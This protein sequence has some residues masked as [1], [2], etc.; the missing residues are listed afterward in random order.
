MTGGRDAR[1]S[2]SNQ[3]LY[4]TISPLI[5]ED[6]FASNNNISREV[7]PLPYERSVEEATQLGENVYNEDMQIDLFCC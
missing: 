4:F 5:K 2:I 7:S 6:I 3:L 1:G